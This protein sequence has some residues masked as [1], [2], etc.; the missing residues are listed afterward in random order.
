M[1][2]SVT[3]TRRPEQVGPVDESG[4]QIREWL[5]QYGGAAVRVADLLCDRHATAPGRIALRYQDAAG[6]AAQLTFAELRD[7]SARS[8]TSP[9]DPD[10]H[11]A[12]GGGDLTPGFE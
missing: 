12:A 5:Q 11:T 8:N 9:P 3:Q 7:R 10:A 4:I 1:S 2:T 6:Q